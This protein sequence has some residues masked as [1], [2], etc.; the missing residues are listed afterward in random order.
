[1][2]RTGASARVTDEVAAIAA[3]AT[4]ASLKIRTV[5]RLIQ[6]N[7]TSWQ[8]WKGRAVDRHLDGVDAGNA[9]HRVDQRFKL[10]VFAKTSAGLSR[11][12]ARQI[13]RCSRPVD[14]NALH[15]R[16]RWKANRF[17]TARRT[18]NGLHGCIQRD[19]VAMF[20]RAF[21]GQRRP[22]GNTERAHRRSVHLR[23]VDVQVA[24]GRV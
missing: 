13:D 1:M 6:L 14:A 18:G 4:M 16:G 7:M 10:S 20:A 15:A 22:H 21:A 9:R 17:G 5:E 2:A 8:R 23:E 11:Y 3:R 24:T 19:V 12:L